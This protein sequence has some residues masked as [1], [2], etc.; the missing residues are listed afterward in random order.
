MAV[1][2][3]EAPGEVGGMEVWTLLCLKETAGQ[4]PTRFRMDA[5]TKA[6]GGE[7]CEKGVWSGGGS[8]R[9]KRRGMQGVT[10]RW[11]RQVGQGKLPM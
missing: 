4:D 8:R 11:E 6:A 9:S 5:R 7:G 10:W 2:M 1:L 3:C